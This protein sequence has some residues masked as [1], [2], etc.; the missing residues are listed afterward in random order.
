RLSRRQFN[1]ISTCSKPKRRDPHEDGVSESILLT[2]WDHQGLDK[3]VAELDGWQLERV[4]SA[5]LANA[6]ASTSG[7]RAV[8][9]KTD[10]PTILRAVTDRAHGC[11]VPV[12]VACADDTARRRAIELKVEEWF[13]CPA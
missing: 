1:A 11:D 7:V 10:D 6:V 9:V 12:V 13:R 8:L 5:E 4:E 3:A 2:D